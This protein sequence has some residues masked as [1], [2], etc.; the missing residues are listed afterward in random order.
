MPRGPRRGVMAAVRSPFENAS[1]RFSS[2]SKRRITGLRRR[3]RIVQLCALMAF[4]YLALS[5]RTCSAGLSSRS[6]I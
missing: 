3:L 2:F 4:A 5:R 1:L 6:P